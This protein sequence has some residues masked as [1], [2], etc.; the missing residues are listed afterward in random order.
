MNKSSFS[1][2]PRAVTL[3]LVCAG[4]SACTVTLLPPNVAPT[5][6]MTNSVEQAQ[7]KLEE[8][9][10]ERAAVEG[11][12]ASEEA[13]C[14]QKFFVNDCLDKAKEQ[15]RSALAYLRAVELEA[16]Y[17]VR[18][19]EADARDRELAASAKAFAEEEARLLAQ[20]PQPSKPEKEPHAPKPR[21]K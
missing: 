9:R 7:R 10:I 18:K 4:L 17:F 3:A 1:S 12:F 19:S 11:R 16:E 14:Y 20:P 8:T 21:K 13:V 2:L 5:V 6:P 15:R